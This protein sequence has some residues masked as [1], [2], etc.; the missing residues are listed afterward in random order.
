MQLQRTRITPPCSNNALHIQEITLLSIE[1]YEE[2]EEHIPTIR[3][4]WWLRS[5][6]FASNSAAGVSTDGSV[7]ADGDYVFR[8]R[9]VVRPALRV[10]N[11]Q[12]LDLQIGDKIFDL[13]GHTWTVIADDLMLCDDGIGQ[14]CFRDDWEAEDSNVYEASDVKKYLDSWAKKNHIF[15]RR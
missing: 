10:S 8:T 9:V 12:S 13:A 4:W 2:A 5:P 11:L 6:G 7:D 14:H 1:E 15:V 3:G